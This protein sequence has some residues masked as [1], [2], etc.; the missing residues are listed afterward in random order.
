MQSAQFLLTLFRDLAENSQ[1][2]GCA[3]II[4]LLLSSAGDG[5]SME[6]RDRDDWNRTAGESAGFVKPTPVCVGF[7]W[8]WRGRWDFW[9]DPAR[10]LRFPA[11][12]SRNRLWVVL[13]WSAA[14][15]LV[16][17]VGFGDC[18]GLE[19]TDFFVLIV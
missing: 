13:G 7:W 16:I 5:I 6:Q 9:L 19:L 17:G 4:L 10:P 15:G 1:E 3:G 18:Y 8:I 14:V 2:V 11:G 12:F